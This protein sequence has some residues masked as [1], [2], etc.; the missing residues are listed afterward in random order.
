MMILGGDVAGKAIQAIVRRAGGTFACNFRGKGYEL[1]DGEGLRALEQLIADHGYYPYRMD[2]GELEARVEDGSIDEVLVR[3][4]SERLEHWL[5]LA[6]ERLRPH[7][8]DVYWMLGNDDPPQL[9]ALFDDA[10][11]GHQAEGNVFQ[12]DEDGHQLVSF[13][14]SN[15]TPW[16]SYREMTEEDLAAHLA[17]L[18]GQLDDPAT[19]VFNFHVPPFGTG[20]DEAP[21]LDSELRVQ[22]AV[23]QV[24]MAA[25]GSTAV[26]EIIERLQ[27][28]ASLHG[29]VHES[30]GFRR[31]GRTI[32]LNPGS[33]YGTGTLNGVLITLEKDRVKAHQFVRG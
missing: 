27:P 15:L 20:L 10:P 9:A 8:L 12:L 24:K 3:L 16:D 11:W 7:R 28:M 29:H 5:Q 22:T 14:Y 26:K 25:V 4:M 17:G 31:I 23:G 13:G 1:E 18:C 6:D 19:S 30:A 21:V 2:P 33:D 32:A